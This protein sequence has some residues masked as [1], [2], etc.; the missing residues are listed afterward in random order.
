VIVTADRILADLAASDIPDE[1]PRVLTTSEVA[2]LCGVTPETVRNWA[3]RGGGP[4]YVRTAG[5]HR[6][7][8]ETDVRDYLADRRRTSPSA[9]AAPPP[10]RRPRRGMPKATC[11]G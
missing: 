9:T 10:P 7:Y 11:Q 8:M 4:P 5:G 3:R 1:E 2:D 6:R